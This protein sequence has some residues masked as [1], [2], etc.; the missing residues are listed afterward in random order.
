MSA[1]LGSRL[2]LASFAVRGAINRKVAK[3]L[4][5]RLVAV[6]GVHYVHT[7]VVYPYPADGKGGTGFTM[8][9]PITES[10]LAVDAWPDHGGAYV[11][12]ASC[13]WFNIEA[14]EGEL[15]GLGFAILGRNITGLTLDH[16]QV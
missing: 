16:A 15:K 10:F 4:I 3:V 1:D 13:Q 5:D 9:Q 2:M 11:V 14:V 8:L 6:C 12:V 7:P